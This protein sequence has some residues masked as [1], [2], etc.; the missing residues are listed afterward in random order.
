MR[1]LI[2]TLG[3]WTLIEGG[4]TLIFPRCTCKLAGVLSKSI[5]AYLSGQNM[6][7]IRLLGLC[8]L[9]FGLGLLALYKFGPG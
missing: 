4:V 5:R 3:I 9:I 1:T 6:R 8:E 2:L 7:D